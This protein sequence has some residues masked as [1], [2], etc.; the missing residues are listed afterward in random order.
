METRPKHASTVLLVRPDKSGAFEV[1]LTRRPDAM[2]FLGGFYVFPG[3]SIEAQDRAKNVLARCR[4][5]VPEEAERLLGNTLGPELAVAHW[6]AGIRELFEEVGIVLL[7][8]AS[9]V[10]VRSDSQS[11]GRFEE[12]RRAIVAG[13]SDFGEFLEAENLYID[14]RRAVYFAHR[15]T[16][17]FFPIRF[18]TRFYL[19][20]LP[21]G[22]SALESSEEVTHALWIA[23]ADAL[24]E[25]NKNL[26]MLPPTTTM[27]Q[28]LG[29]FGSWKSLCEKFS[30]SVQR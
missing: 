20:A 11:R 27:L 19:A 9:G 24:Q 23:P 10:E 14:L 30:L 4:G 12:K 17:E 8:D 13:A 22:Q 2:R 25:A 3:G 6:I 16:P 21:Q 7:S 15:V 26:P 28:T 18:D 29:G 5:L 1:L